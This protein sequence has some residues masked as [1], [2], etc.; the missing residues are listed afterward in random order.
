MRLSVTRLIRR[1][2]LGSGLPQWVDKM[3]DPINAFIEQASRAFDRGITFRENFLGVETTQ[4]FIHDTAKEINT[5]SRLR[6]KGVVLVDSS[7]EIV[8]G[9]GWSRVD[10]GNISVTARFASGGATEKACVLQIQLGA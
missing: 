7:G 9:F 2:D 4:T 3:L 8:T 1:D 10:N 5:G 6:V